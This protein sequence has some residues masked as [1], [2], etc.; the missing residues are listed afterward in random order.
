MAASPSGEARQIGDGK[1]LQAVNTGTRTG[2]SEEQSSLGR[3]DKGE[4]RELPRRAS[5]GLE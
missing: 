3:P 2:S 4:T 5:T 1:I